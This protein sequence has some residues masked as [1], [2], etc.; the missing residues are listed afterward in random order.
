[1]DGIYQGDN[2]S[3]AAGRDDSSN[4]CSDSSSDRDDSS[5]ECSDS[6]SDRDDS[7][8]ECSNSSNE[9]G[10]G[11]SD[12][13]RAFASIARKIRSPDEIR[14]SRLPVPGFHPGYMA[15]MKA[16]SHTPASAEHAGCPAPG[17]RSTVFR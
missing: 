5:S 15:S 14:G 1:M 16:R 8:S 9:C 11:S 7:S 3:D 6:S 12:L 17:F 4:E 2:Y 10:I 13:H